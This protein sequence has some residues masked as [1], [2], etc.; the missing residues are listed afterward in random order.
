M[1]RKRGASQTKASPPATL[2]KSGGQPDPFQ[3]L[4]SREGFQISNIKEAAV[5]R[6]LTQA[7]ICGVSFS[8]KVPGP[9][10]YADS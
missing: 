3:H 10:S 7:S 4:E 2:P 8:A 6:I 5:K 9:E 1:R